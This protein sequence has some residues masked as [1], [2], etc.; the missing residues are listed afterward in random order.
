MY[1]QNK[2]SSRSFFCSSLSPCWLSGYPSAS[3]QRPAPSPMYLSSFKSGLLFKGTEIFFG[4]QTA[5]QWIQPLNQVGFSNFFSFLSRNRC[6]KRRARYILCILHAGTVREWV[7]TISCHPVASLISSNVI[8]LSRKQTVKA[9]DR[10]VHRPVPP[11]PSSS[12]RFAIFSFSLPI[13]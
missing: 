6:P 1:C 8:H 13:R 4:Y 9:S 2:P 12:L 3:S 7:E 10:L 11:F 5:A